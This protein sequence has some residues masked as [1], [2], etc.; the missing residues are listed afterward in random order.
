MRYHATTM[1]P[2]LCT[3]RSL[4][5]SFAVLAAGVRSPA[6]D[7]AH[8]V[9]ALCRPL[10]LADLAVGFV[11][12]VIDG[13]DQLVRGYGKLA[14]DREAVPDADT[15]YEI[16]SVSKV[17]TGLLLADAAQR[18][19]VALDDPVQKHLPAGVEL[20][21]FQDQPILLWHLAT[22]TSGLP[23]MPRLEAED[24][25]NPYAHID[26]EVMRAI[27]ADARPRRVPGSSYE[28]SNL[29][30]GMLGWLLVHKDGSTT[31]DELLRKRITGPLAMADTAS[32]LTAELRAR[33]APPHDGD[34]EVSHVWDLA[35]MAGAGGIR[36]SMADMLKF[37]RL[38][39]APS[40]PLADA[41]RL[42]QQ[43]RHDG[44]GGIG[45]A[46]GWHLARDGVSYVHNGQTG[47]FHAW[48][49]VVPSTSRG[50]CILTNTSAGQIDTVGE[51]ILQ[52]LHG[53]AVAPL[54]FAAAVAVPR[55]QLQR[56]VGKYRMAPGTEFDITLDQR[57][58]RAQL[59]G[60]PSLR[61]FAKSPTDFF[62]RA[63]EASITFEVEGDGVKALVLHQ[64]GRDLKCRR[65]PDAGK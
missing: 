1:V 3:L 33:L 64:N 18:G 65:L 14:A 63:V 29:G 61:L 11:V 21:P 9:D 54:Q 31:Y 45:M 19:L 44:Q 50:V 28:Y 8:R 2:W 40:G 26:D 48:L 42:Q 5:L 23:R 24:P 36:S 12:G 46:L 6:Q 22:H 37:M 10:L 62:Y 27:V 20:R 25:G 47:G 57:G 43:K 35:M 13:A 15:L 7:L 56:L 49:G 4:S 38:Q 60:Q 32:V 30:A 52:A 41:V 17:F 53:S 39:L 34:G 55:E 59:T 58:L 51:R 16:G